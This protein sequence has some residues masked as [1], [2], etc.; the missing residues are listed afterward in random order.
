MRCALCG[1]EVIA[2]NA[3]LFRVNETGTTGIFHCELCYKGSIDPTIA[4]IIN[5]IKG[6]G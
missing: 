4:D 2:D 5:A 6:E 1:R 3:T